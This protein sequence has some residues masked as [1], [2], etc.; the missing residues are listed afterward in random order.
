MTL[1]DAAR[2]AIVSGTLSITVDPRDVLA[3]AEQV[4]RLEARIEEMRRR[5]EP[6][7]QEQ[8]EDMDDRAYAC[9]G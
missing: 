4:A 2:A 6:T 7:M 8:I 9:W 5:Y 3:L 1:L